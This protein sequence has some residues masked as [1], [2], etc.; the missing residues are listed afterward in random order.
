MWYLTVGDFVYNFTG[1]VF[2]IFLPALLLG[3]VTVLNDG[4]PLY[5]KKSWQQI[6]MRLCFVGAIVSVLMFACPY[7]PAE[8]SMKNRVGSYAFSLVAIAVSTV[9]V[10]FV[11]IFFTL[12][13]QWIFAKPKP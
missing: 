12:L 6:F 10:Y 8:L 13:M 4:N 9:V 3:T 11:A 1:I 2:G 5:L 7:F